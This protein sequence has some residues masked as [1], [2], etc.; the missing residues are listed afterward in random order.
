MVVD[1]GCIQRRRC[2]ARERHIRF[3][4]SGRN[5]RVS[6]RARAAYVLAVRSAGRTGHPATHR[7]ICADTETPLTTIPV[8]ASLYASALHIPVSMSCPGSISITTQS[9]AELILIIAPRE[10]ALGAERL[11]LRLAPSR[12]WLVPAPVGRRALRP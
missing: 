12:I 8:P 6:D 5:W 3:A 1:A 7:V 10:P 2:G 11:G 9:D 4:G